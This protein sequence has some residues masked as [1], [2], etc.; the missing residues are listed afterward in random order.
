MSTVPKFIHLDNQRRGRSGLN[1][2]DLLPGQVSEAYNV[3]GFD[4]LWG[5][6]R[7]GADSLSL[8]GGTAFTGPMNALARFVPGTDDTAAEMWGIDGAATPIWK[9]LAAGTSWAD[10]TVDDAITSRAQDANLAVLNGKLFVTYKSAKARMHVYDPLL[11]TPRVRVVGINPGVTAPTAA[12]SGGAGTLPATQLY[13]RVR[14]IQA[15]AA[16]GGTLY[17]RSEPTPSVA[18]T[19]TGANLT[20]TVTRPT[21]PGEGET[22]WEVEL[23]PDNVAF[24]RVDGWDANFGVGSAAIAIATT[25]DV[26]G[27]GRWTGY[28]GMILSEPSG[29]FTLPHSAKFIVSDDNRLIWAGDYDGV[30]PGS[31]VWFSPVLNSAQKGDDE[32]WVNTNFQKNYI[33]LGT[34][35]G[36]EITALGYPLNGVIFVFKYRAIWALYPTG[37]VNGPYIRRKLREDIGCV[38]QKS[39]QLCRDVTGRN[40]LHFWDALTG[41]WRI[42]SQGGFEYLGRDMEDVT[43]TVN[44]A[45]TNRV[46][47]SIWHTG[48]HQWWIY[49]AVGSGNDPS[50]KYVFDP[51]LVQKD[52][53]GLLR[54]GWYKHDGDSAVARCSCLFANTVAASMSSY[55][56]PYVG[57]TN[58]TAKV[59]KCD[60]DTATDDAGTAFQAYIDSGPVYPPLET[61]VMTSIGEAILTAKAASGVTIQMSTEADF[62]GTARTKTSTAL[63]T[64]ESTET[65]VFKKF[66]DSNLSDLKVFQVRLG[67]ASAVSSGWVIDRLSIPLMAEGT[68]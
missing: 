35:D 17:R 37:D 66:E 44:L 28:T 21:A 49:L 27:S 56:K 32:R 22:H 6:K 2:F 10:V 50:V 13:I 43:P 61:G 58:G 47:H 14:F 18:F 25:T 64:P 68:A 5:R 1:P 7:G 11:A 30:Q 8:T 9:R 65:R 57:L 39:V 23:S 38:D 31:R 46:M 26:I 33:D 36:G 59:Y 41:P 34:K 24:Y 4:G 53:E 42:S 52:E 16:S 29:L 67:D 51:L 40:A 45:A 15:S 3:D 12:N 54:G 19:P 60:S 20:V 55:L 62:G 63:L 48:K